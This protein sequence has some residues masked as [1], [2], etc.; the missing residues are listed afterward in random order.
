MTMETL[1]AFVQEYITKNY[2]QAL[3]AQDRAFNLRAYIEKCL[4]DNEDKAKELISE[5]YTVSDLIDIIYSD[6]AEYSVLTEYLKRDDIE[7]ININGWDDIAITTTDGVTKKSKRHFYSTQ[8]AT[9]VIKRLLHESGMVIDNATPVAQGHLPGNTRITALK[10]PIVDKD[11]GVAVSI[12]IIHM[13]TFC[14]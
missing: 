9:D 6:M 11:R 3:S 4:K 5:G 1:S 12:R 8:H 10:D 2:P 14:K 7:E 13:N